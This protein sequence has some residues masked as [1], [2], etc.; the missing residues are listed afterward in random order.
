[1]SII[2]LARRVLSEGPGAV[3]DYVSFL[4]SGGSMYP[5]DA[6]KLAGVDLTTPEPVNVTFSVLSD[7]VDQLQALLDGEGL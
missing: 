4:K 5:L 2:M 6:L 3:A 7:M 1:M